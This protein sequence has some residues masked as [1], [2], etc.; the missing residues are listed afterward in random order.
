MVSRL[1]QIEI[2]IDNMERV[3][4][5]SGKNRDDR[6]KEKQKFRRR[7]AGLSDSELEVLSRA[8]LKKLKQGSH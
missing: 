5:A 6:F 3:L 7:L 2:I 4:K 1:D 8:A